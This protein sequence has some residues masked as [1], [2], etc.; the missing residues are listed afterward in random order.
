MKLHE[1][2]NVPGG[3]SGPAAERAAE[4]DTPDAMR[5][6][7]WPKRS[8]LDHHGRIARRLAPSANW[9]T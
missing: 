8:R 3:C 4:G 1:E 6:T 5:G 7:A 2:G 9:R